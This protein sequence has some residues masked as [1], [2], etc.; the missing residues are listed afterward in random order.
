MKNKPLVSIVTPTYNHEKYIAQCIESVLAQTYDN[1]EQIIIDDGSSDRTS[2]IIKKYK[3]SRIHYIRQE[4]LGIWQL[5]KTYNK[6]LDLSRGDFIAI[7]EGDDCWPE[8]KLEKQLP[9]FNNNKVVLSWGRGILIDANSKII[10]EISPQNFDRYQEIY[11]NTPPGMA[12]RKLLLT[13]FLNPTVTVIVRRKALI[14]IGGFKQPSGVPYVDFPTWLEICLKGEFC[15]VNE[16][17]GYWRRHSSQITSAHSAEVMFGHVKASTNFYQKL[18][19][20]Q[21]IIYG[22]KDNLIAGNNHW[23]CGRAYLIKKKWKKAR[24]EF[25]K[26][27][28]KG[29]LPIKLKLKSFGGLIFSF[30][31]ISSLKRKLFFFKICQN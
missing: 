31:H 24:R 5:A 11:Q 22:I 3:D 28:T 1:W 14:E 29:S 26:A 12:L 19:S 6:A 10:G 27:I 4:N 20:E 2:E 21:K 15:F 7:L 30:F 9:Y 18:S 13:N 8:D 16:T 17:L 25:F 23:L